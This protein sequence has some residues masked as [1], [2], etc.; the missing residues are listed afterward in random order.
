MSLSS[1]DAKKASRAINPRVF[2]EAR[3]AGSISVD[4]LDHAPPVEMAR[5]ARARGDTRTP[6]R[7]FYGWAV[8]MAR[9][10]ASNGRTVEPTPLPSNPYHADIRLHL[11]DEPWEREELRRQ[12][13]NELAAHSVWM[14]LESV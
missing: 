10:A 7:S 8:L 3:D 14:S 4:R 5:L 2:L 13:A 1:K 12:H 11:P 6:P 9:E